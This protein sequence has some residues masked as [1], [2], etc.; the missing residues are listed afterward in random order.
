MTRL[1]G[2]RMA[3]LARTAPRTL[4]LG[5][6]ALCCALTLAGTPSAAWASIRTSD[7]VDGHSYK[8]LGVP[9]AAM[10]DVEM[11]AGVLVTEDGRVLWSRNPDDQRAMASIT[12]IMTA[13]V[14]LENSDPGDI[15]TVSPEAVSVGESTSFLRAGEK[16]P[17]HELLEALLVKSGND[18]AFAIA[19]HVAGSEEAFVEMM[20]AKATELGLENTH[21]ENPHGL[22]E[23]GHHSS[24]ADLSV[25]ARYAMTKPAFR[26]I[27][28]EKTARIGTGKRSEKVENTNI[29][30]GNYA[31][32]NGVK[33][34]WTN[35]A[36]HSVIVSANRDGVELYA[37]VLGTP[38]DLQRFKDAKALLDFGFSHYRTQS[39]VSAGTV[40]GEA[41]VADYLDVTVPA[42][43]S[44][45][46]TTTVFDLSGDIT[47]SV[48][49]AAVRAPVAKG[50]DVGV[51]RFVQNDTVIASVPLV[52]TEDVAKP[53]PIERIGIAL[54]RL[55]RRITGS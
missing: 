53:N 47:R 37:V 29:L 27:V 4:A 41:P 48:T 52:A 40:I 9:K 36:G 18:A 19:E 30:L 42:S 22:D 39:L 12:K 8:E 35:D 21:F 7:R 11:K 24:A 33:T 38:T 5:V 10:P 50:D 32:A 13:I 15:V 51:A 26:E 1:S 2:T 14:A 23:K 25:L 54:V 20:N 49:T 6:A 43:V 44:T 34:G 31:G 55:W 28:G 16:L 45:D 46:V 3:R 17:M